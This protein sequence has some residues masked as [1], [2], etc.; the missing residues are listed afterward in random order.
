[1]SV[2]VP[3]PLT[4]VAVP[5]EEPVSS[6]SVGA[7]ATVTASLNLTVM[8]TTSSI[9]KTPFVAVEDTADTV[10]AAVLTVAALLTDASVPFD[11]SIISFDE[12]VF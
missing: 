12:S 5:S 6:S 9:P 11:E 1:M 7:P 8:G 4:Y 10:G 3:E 2:S